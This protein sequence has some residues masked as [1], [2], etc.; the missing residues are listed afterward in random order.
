MDE[1][2]DVWVS[3]CLPL[4]CS[5]QPSWIPSYAI[6][7]IPVLWDMLDWEIVIQWVFS[8]H[9]TAMRG[10]RQNWEHFTLPS[11]CW[12]RRGGLFLSAQSCDGEVPAPCSS[13]DW[14][15]KGDW[16]SSGEQKVDHLPVTILLLQLNIRWELL[17]ITGCPWAGD[18]MLKGCVLF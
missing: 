4:T 12:A 1:R 9:S 15:R 5:P 14:Q 18:N 7:P 3:P 2:G 11:R 8:K 6:K 17:N 10:E 16:L 13:A